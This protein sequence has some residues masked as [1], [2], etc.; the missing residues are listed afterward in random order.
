MF[1]PAAASEPAA[2]R[3]GTRA[4]TVIS[5]HGKWGLRLD[6]H[7]H[8]ARDAWHCG[9][10]AAARWRQVDVPG[11]WEDHGYDGYNG[12]AW[13]RRE[14]DLPPTRAAAPRALVLA[15]V[16]ADTRVWLNG[17]LL[18]PALEPF[19]RFVVAID[20]AARGGRNRICVRVRE[21][22]GPGGVIRRAFIASYQRLADLLPSEWAG[23]PARTPCDWL[24]SAVVYQVFPRCFSA[25]A[26]FDAITARLD[27]LVA[28]GV[29]VLQLLPIH[30]IGHEGRKGTYGSPYAPTDLHAIDPLYGDA[31]SFRR[32]VDEAHARDMK[33]IFDL[34]ADHTA[35]DAN[36]RYQRPHFYERDAA[37]HVHMPRP[38]W[39]DVLKLDLRNEE[40]QQ[41]ILSVMEYWV[42]NFGV[43]GFR[44]DFADASPPE[45]LARVRPRLD[46]IRPMLLMAEGELPQHHLEVFDLT[47]DWRTYLM[48]GGL[49]KGRMRAADFVNHLTQ[50]RLDYPRGSLRL[51]FSSNHDLCY[52]H[53]PAPQRYGPALLASVV[54]MYGLPGVPL[55]YNGQEIGN[56]KKLELFE[57]R[58]IDWHVRNESVYRLY[59]DLNRLRRTRPSLQR[60]DTQMIGGLAGEQVLPMSRE[61]ADEQTLFLVNLAT[62]PQDV[63]LA[64]A[65]RG[66]Y[67]TLVSHPAL[68]TP[69]RPEFTLPPLGF[70]VGTPR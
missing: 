27:E 62:E 68:G 42:T 8:G 23:R 37:G 11:C 15:G 6:P 40:L 48:L 41:Y 17:R 38:D 14:F 24:R 28:L 52:L 60:G 58:P 59:R 18:R 55:I 20:D 45:L 67:E 63:N 65:E 46:S 9:D 30:P 26:T 50:E 29:D 5:L 2:Q 31:A 35:P 13:Y 3:A 16:D 66:A 64:A 33:L 7:D 49:R 70:W 21:F 51:R 56:R 69:T 25:P 47:Y 39:P 54:L 1:E 19:Q 43:D 22:G 53:R 44:W 36:L 32:L 61:T 4:G 34:V 57:R 12:P 10:A